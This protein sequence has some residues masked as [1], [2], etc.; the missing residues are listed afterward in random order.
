MVMVKES[1]SAAVPSSLLFLLQQ[2]GIFLLLVFG[3]SCFGWFC[4]FLGASV[5][6]E[7]QLCLVNVCVL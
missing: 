7:N 1:E 6:A 5:A 2:F 3:V 4:S